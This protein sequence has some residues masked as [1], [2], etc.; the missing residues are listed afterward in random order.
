MSGQ[1]VGNL[2][3][4]AKNSSAVNVYDIDAHIASDSGV[5]G[6]NN[7]ALHG[8]INNNTPSPTLDL[9]TSL[10]DFNIAFAGEFVKSLFLTLEVKLTVR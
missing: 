6:D 3:L 1:D 8:T 7:L 10:K 9:T 2:V 5:L 4:N